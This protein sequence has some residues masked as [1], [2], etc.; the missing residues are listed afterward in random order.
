MA[1]STNLK[2]ANNNNSFDYKQ[3]N[4]D[5]VCFWGCLAMIVVYGLIIWG[6]FRLWSGVHVSSVFDGTWQPS[7]P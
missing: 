3:A 5:N 4:S 2:L 6:V 1:N 7:Y